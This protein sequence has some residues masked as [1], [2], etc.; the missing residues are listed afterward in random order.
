MS[1]RGSFV[2][3]YMCPKCFEAAKTVL[4][5]ND[6]YLCSCV[7]PSWQKGNELPIIAGKIGA[8]YD[9]GE[10][11]SMNHLTDIL[12]EKICHP[13]RVAVLCAGGQS[14]IILVNPMDKPKNQDIVY[15]PIETDP[16]KR[17]H[18]PMFRGP[19]GYDE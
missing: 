13:V 12:A 15:T 19:R 1:E 11:L 9:G 16:E 3:E 10:I 7:I 17:Y 5:D 4:L 14:E 6:K 2:T 8:M 18:Q